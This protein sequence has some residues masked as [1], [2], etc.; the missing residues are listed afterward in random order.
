M[1]KEMGLEKTEVMIKGEAITECLHY[2]ENG[3][4]VSNLIDKLGP[5]LPF[6]FVSAMLAQKK[7]GYERKMW[8]LSYRQCIEMGL[9]P[10]ANAVV[11][12][13]VPMYAT[14]FIN[15]A[16]G[17]HIKRNE[18]GYE[19]I[20]AL[21]DCCLI[22]RD[23]IFV[24]RVQGEF[25]DAFKCHGRHDD[26]PEI[27][28]MNEAA[29]RALLIKLDSYRNPMVKHDHEEALRRRCESY[30]D[31]EDRQ[32][33][34]SG[35]ALM[36]VTVGLVKAFKGV[37]AN[38]LVSRVDLER[39][40][41]SYEVPELAGDFQEKTDIF[42]KAF[43]TAADIA[44]T[45]VESLDEAGAGKENGFRTLDD[46]VKDTAADSLAGDALASYLRTLAPQLKHNK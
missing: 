4:T 34:A 23:D 8:P 27:W 24:K 13:Y 5:F 29:F 25:F 26:E 45:L 32:D 42:M 22:A 37:D 18:V 38:N 2:F 40:D 9:V 41:K 19:E 14:A 43:D 28:N 10:H 11:N 30:F 7:V 15:V 3:G 16:T 31:E 21:L 17:E 1:K 12:I 46:L 39:A 33:H 44:K 6:G 20:G 35:A 36:E